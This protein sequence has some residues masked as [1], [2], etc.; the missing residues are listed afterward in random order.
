MNI[1]QTYLENRPLIY[2]QCAKEGGHLV[3]RKECYED[4]APYCGEL[5]YLAKFYISQVVNLHVNFANLF[6]IID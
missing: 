1:G 5:K 4:K 6:L 2:G 3:V